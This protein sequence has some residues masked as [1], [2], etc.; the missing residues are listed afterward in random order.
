MPEYKIR[1]INAKKLLDL[2][3][4]TKNEDGVNREIKLDFDDATIFNLVVEEQL[5]M[6]DNALFYQLRQVLGNNDEEDS[7]LLLNEI[8]ILDFNDIYKKKS[9]LTKESISALFEKGFVIKSNNKEIHMMPFDKSGNMSRKC[10]MT[11]ISEERLEEINKRLNLGIDFDEIEV[12]LSK[13]YAYRGLY[14]SSAKRIEHDGLK[15]TP[16]TL[17]VIGDV[18]TKFLHYAKGVIV[19][20]ATVKQMGSECE[21]EFADEVT[22]EKIEAPYDGQGLISPKYAEFINDAMNPAKTINSFQIRLPFAKGMLHNVD[23]HAF[24]EEFDP[25]YNK[26]KDYIIEDAFGF[27]RDLKKAQIIIPK[28]MFKCSKWLKCYCEKRSIKDPMQF[29]CEQVENYNHALY[30]S[31]TDIPYGNSKATHLTYQMLNT[32]ALT[33]EQ[34]N[35]IIKNQLDY[36][37]NP[38]KY[39]ELING[40]MVTEDEIDENASYELPNWQR[41]VMINPVFSKLSYIKGQL[42]NI[43]TSLKT[44]LLFGKIVVSGETRFLARDL[45][46]M[47]VTLIQNNEAKKKLNGYK[48]YDYKFFLPQ[49]DNQKNIELNYEN[50]Y[51][52]FRS[53]HLSRNEQSVLMPVVENQKFKKY[54]E[55]VKSFKKYFSH[56]TG[57]VMFG[58]ESVD[59]AVLGGADFDGD[60]VAMIADENVVKAVMQGC[61]KQKSPEERLNDRDLTRVMPLVKIPSVQ[62]KKEK[63]PKNIPFSLVDST[64]SDRIGIISN[65]AIEIGQ[66]EYGGLEKTDESK[67]S[68]AECTVFTG[69]EIDSAKSGC[70]PKLPEVEIKSS[71][72]LEFKKAFEKLKKTPG[73]HFNQLTVKKNKNG[74]KYELSL[75]GNKT[76]KYERKK[77]TYINDLPIIFM[78]NLNEK[79]NIPYD[80]N[81]SCFDFNVENKKEIDSN[82]KNNCEAVLEV[83]SSYKSI[84]DKLK[85]KNKVDYKKELEKLLF[86]QYDEEN[87][88]K[89]LKEHVPY[90]KEIVVQKI[91][92]KE[93]LKKFEKEIN[94]SSWH[95]LNEEKKLEA[96]KDLFDISEDK[97]CENKEHFEFLLNPYYQGYKALWFIV[98]DIGQNVKIDYSKKINECKNNSKKTVLDS[99]LAKEVEEMMINKLN[100]KEEVSEKHIYGC[101]KRYLN[102]LL[103]KTE[104]DENIKISA[105]FELTKKENSVARFFWESFSWNDLEKYIVK[106]DEHA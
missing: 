15:L 17:V 44:K 38:I 92:T 78:E 72:Y 36:I 102:Q 104:L 61:Y 94:A 20:N 26:E 89:I 55:T 60:L 71:G 8:V 62:A 68:C 14:L 12:V 65:L 106:G 67:T 13:Y 82:F 49:G 41:A 58:F 59:S 45:P 30:V 22:S 4:I 18:Q 3:T 31:S 56:L 105:L 77:G 93:K 103:E 101:C 100:N 95:L 63:V 57:V 73:Y 16:E 51:A 1:K 85:P 66:S 46:H 88:G 80:K 81:S 87:V 29:Y 86:K 23:F 43:Q 32:L 70:R 11:F 64:F 5:V 40:Q 21:V 6:D 37:E 33:E 25:N 96:L 90:I 9:D 53:P 52:F 34:F 91:N 19:K 97:I 76:I 83:Y 28:S 2:E 98:K 79:M 99:D 39:L 27:K 10:R 42:T 7:E 74:D 47:L 48:I 54:N 50:C 84:L 35:A 69:L 75:K 24:F